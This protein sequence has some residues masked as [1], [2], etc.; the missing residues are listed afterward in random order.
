MFYDDNNSVN[1]QRQ[2]WVTYTHTHPCTHLP[3]KCV[4]VCVGVVSVCGP[5][6]WIEPGLVQSTAVSFE[7]PKTKRAL[8]PATSLFHVFIW[9][10]SSSPYCHSIQLCG[11]RLQLVTTPS[12]TSGARGLI[13][14]LWIFSRGGKKKLSERTK[15]SCFRK[16]SSTNTVHLSCLRWKK[17]TP[18]QN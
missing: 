2:L 10:H 9:Y 6:T 11:P 5:P 14:S 17:K 7:R 15:C 18:K 16:M 13:C 3:L 4:C 12:S 1:L 8:N